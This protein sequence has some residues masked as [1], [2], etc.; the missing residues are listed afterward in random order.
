MYSSEITQKIFYGYKNNRLL[1][2]IAAFLTTPEI[3]F[4]FLP[5]VLR[6]SPVDLVGIIDGGIR[7]RRGNGSDSLNAITS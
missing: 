5:T 1:T 7:A 3:F 6:S 2:R 4:W